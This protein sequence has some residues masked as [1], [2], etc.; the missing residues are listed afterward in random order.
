MAKVV[1]LKKDGITISLTRPVTQKVKIPIPSW[2]WDTDTDWVACRRG[3]RRALDR[4]NDEL[5]TFRIEMEHPTSKLSPQLNSYL[6]VLDQV[7][8][9]LKKERLIQT[10]NWK[11]VIRRLIL[12]L[13]NHFEDVEKALKSEELMEFMPSH[14][15]GSIQNRSLFWLNRHGSAYYEM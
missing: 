11:M 15:L 1:E 9:T 3:I 4:L 8:E 6:D 2:M 10:R 14:L 12:F 13:K 5:A 7:L